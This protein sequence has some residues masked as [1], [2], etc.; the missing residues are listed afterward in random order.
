M[1]FR[2]TMKDPDGVY[3][4]LADA[5]KESVKDAKVEDEN[6]REALREY[7]A[8]KI[9]DFAGQWLEYGE[10][11]EIEFDTEAGTAVL[12]KTK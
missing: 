10:Y 11:A 9:R 5:A 3:D 7:R 4:S 12:V 8:Q 6:E 2:V 1:K